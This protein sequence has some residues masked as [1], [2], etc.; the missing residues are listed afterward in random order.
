MRR[1]APK[2][3]NWL[4]LLLAI[5]LNTWPVLLW[6]VEGEATI[7]FASGYRHS[8]IGMSWEEWQSLAKQSGADPACDG[9]NCRIFDLFRTYTFS[10][11]KQA[12]EP[13]R[14]YSKSADAN[15]GGGPYW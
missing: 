14:I 7:S 4:L 12:D 13:L 5:L 8:Y 10:F 6:L 1:F 3:T 9:T 11:R 2:R 15:F